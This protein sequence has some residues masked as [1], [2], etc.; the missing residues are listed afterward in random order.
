MLD[1][2]DFKKIIYNFL[3]V[4]L[5]LSLEEIRSRGLSSDEKYWERRHLSC[6][7]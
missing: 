4:I 3:S 7:L 1:A 6:F 2:K 5:D